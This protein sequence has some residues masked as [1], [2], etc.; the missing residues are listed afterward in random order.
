MAERLCLGCMEK[1]NDKYDVCP[2]CGYE[3]GTPAKEA[4]HMTP[5]T[6]L[7]GKYIV[8]K[9]VGYG[10]FGVT[11]IGYDG[12]LEKKIAIKEYLPSEFATRMPGQPEVTVYSGEREEQFYS[13]IDKFVEEGKRL[14]QFK[15]VPGIVR[16]F[17]SFTANK[18][19]YIVMEYL[20]GETLKTRLEREGKLSIETSLD[21]IMPILS[22]LQEVHKIGIIH[23]DIAPD[24]IF[25]TKDG[26]VKL[27]DF[28][29]ARYATT[30]HSKSLSVI[31]KQGY[32]P[33][34]QYRSKGDQGPW[35]DVYACG[36]TL[37]KML[38]GITPEDSMERAGKDTLQPPSKKGAK[39]SKNLDTAIMNALNIRIEDRTQSAEEFKEELI[40]VTEVK[41][42]KAH[43][44]KMDIGKWPLWVK[45]VSGMAACGIITF[46]V[47]LATGVIHFNMKAIVDNGLLAS[48]EVYV[49]NLINYSVEQAETKTIEN[50]LVLQ[51]VDKQNSDIIPKEKIL[52]QNLQDGLVVE[53][54]TTIEV[55]V[56][57]GGE[58]VYIEELMGMIL[59]DAKSYLENISM[60]VDVIE[61]ESE[62]AP[63]YVI[64][65]EVVNGEEIIDASN[66]VEKGSTFRL[67]VS[68]G[69]DDIDE[70]KD[71]TVPDVVGMDYS[72]ATNSVKKA[73]MYI[74]RIRSEYSDTVPK[75]QIMEQELAAGS[76]VKQGT[77]LGVVVSLGA[78]TTRVPDVQYKDKNTATS[79]LT[80]NNLTYECK[81]EESKTV[82]KDHVIRQ[83]IA[84][85]SEVAIQTKVVLYISSGGSPASSEDKSEATTES[86]TESTAEEQ[87]VTVAVP[88]LIGCTEAEAKKK[89]EAVGLKLGIVTK[90]EHEG[91]K[92]GRVFEQGTEKNTKVKKGTAINVFICDNSSQKVTVP[93][94]IGCTEAEAK[95]KLEAVGLV[96]GSVTKKEHAGGTNGKVF[97]QSVEKNSKVNKGTVVDI[98][99]CDNSTAKVEVPNLVGMSEDQARLILESSNLKLG[100][101]EYYSQP[102]SKSGNVLSLSRHSS[103]SVGDKVAK[104]TA[105]DIE[106]CN[107]DQLTEYRTVTYDYKNSAESSISG[108]TKVGITY[109]DYGAE[110]Y[111]GKT[112]VAEEYQKDYYGTSYCTRKVR[113]DYYQV[114]HNY[115]GPKLITSGSD[116]VGWLKEYFDYMWGRSHNADD[117]TYTDELKQDVKDWQ[118]SWNQKHPDDYL[119]ID[120]LAGEKTVPKI[121]QDWDSY[122]ESNP[123]YYYQ[124]RIII[125]VFQKIVYG[126]WKRTKT[127]DNDETRLVYV[128]PSY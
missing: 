90:M 69:Q 45:I 110:I 2:Y 16:I 29:A 62:I 77:K 11:Y 99:I 43:D 64:R 27:L 78:Q 30:T 94:L 120:G 126:E 19:A 51:I 34:E 26:E 96:L 65:Y 117:L 91:G 68:K 40:S 49:P 100:N 66:G 76:V 36:A 73:K 89:L 70:T 118:W 12:L 84:A 103:I 38:T 61:E 35:T 125:N 80:Q 10:G 108:Y 72:K 81:Y 20:E 59:E 37:Y 13:G 124:D 50:D 57:A 4:Y 127:N 111:N 79:L 7:S 53:S 67:Y 48:G 31:I 56:S 101:V 71:T 102:G 121:K 25:L 15:D 1:I 23:R 82:A 9:V 109:G 58:I 55:A 28:G 86:T 75:N 8:G 116:G 21:I 60:V 6:V 104:N 3:D 42:K 119:T 92:D 112:Y 46:G 85:G 95:K 54:G 128:Y 5:G 22:A 33:E 24:N 39:T 87:E 114:R 52:S 122:I 44:R 47:L 74:Y 93:N 32:A 107:N 63:G 106:V 97:E 98:C 14:A 88:D 123:D 115:P 18:T 83:S 17:D 105:I 41:R 113:T